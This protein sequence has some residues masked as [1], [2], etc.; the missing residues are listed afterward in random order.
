MPARPSLDRRR[1]LLQM[2]L[3]LAPCLAGA[4]GTRAG[5][6]TR[7]DLHGLG[8]IELP[9]SFRLRGLDTRHGD[10]TPSAQLARHPGGPLVFRFDAHARNGWGGHALDPM[11]LQVLLF[12]PARPGELPERGF[13]IERYF[14][15][16]GHTI[17]LDDPR[18][19]QRVEGGG[20]DRQVWRWLAM[21]DGYA[22]S[23]D[24]RWAMCVYDTGRAV[25]LDLFVWRRLLER[26]AAEALLREALAGLRLLPA[27][28]A[29]FAGPDTPEARQAMLR[30]R[31]VARFFDA[32]APLGIAPAAPGQ[33]TLGPDAAAWLDADGQALGAVVALATLGERGIASR[34]DEGRPRLTLSRSLDALPAHTP[35][36]LFRSSSDE[37]WRLTAVE[38]PPRAVDWPLLPAE[39]AHA[40]RLGPGTMAQLVLRFHAYHPPVLD[41]A[42]DVPGFL[43]D[44]QRWRDAL[45]AGAVRGMAPED[46]NTG[47]LR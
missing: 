13:S 3:G 12:D 35:M 20:I 46:I 9:A 22:A 36:L 24:P 30:A 47:A 38:S 16:T 2:L 42:L 39:R 19:Q 44:V 27:R 33:V 43:N 37:A 41:D 26:D 5:D 8:S 23:A 17:A 4:A 25:R 28:D 45:R 34:D 29:F 21:N 15:L 32:L 40:A 6:A 11:L 14:S 10:L 18:W 7:H 31:H 1:R